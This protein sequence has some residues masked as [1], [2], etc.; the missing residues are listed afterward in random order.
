M[1]NIV[2]SVSM[3]EGLIEELSELKNFNLLKSADNIHLIHIYNKKSKYKLPLSVNHEDFEEVEKYVV[4]KLHAISDD[5]MP[6]HK[7]KDGDRHS[8]CVFNGNEKI[9]ILEYLKENQADLII[10]STRGEQGLTGLFK[11]SFSFWL[12]E[13][14]PCNVLIIRP[15]QKTE[16]S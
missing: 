1:K 2:I 6:G 11:D 7:N 4:D 14:A 13:H 8:L 10:A 16:Q 12:T 9:K 5:L 3:D 15:K